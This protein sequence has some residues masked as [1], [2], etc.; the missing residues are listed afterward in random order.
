MDYTGFDTI[1]YNILWFMIFWFDA[2]VCGC[3]WKMFIST[4]I[5]NIVVTGLGT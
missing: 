3:M 2:S 1:E 4:D 5:L